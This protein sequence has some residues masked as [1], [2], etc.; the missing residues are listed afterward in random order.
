VPQIDPSL[1]LPKAIS[2]QKVPYLSITTWKLIG[3]I[4][5]N[6]FVALKVDVYESGCAKKR[7]FSGI[8]SDKDIYKPYGFRKILAKS[9]PSSPLSL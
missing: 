2:H 4:A 5:K 7:E 6:S 9:L 8:Q 3:F 1:P